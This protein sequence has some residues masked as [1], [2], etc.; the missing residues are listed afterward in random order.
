[1][2][3]NNPIVS[4]HD[5]GAGGLSNA[6]PELVHDA[7]RG[8]RFELRTIPNDDP[9]MSPMEIWCNEAQERYVLA[10]SAARLAE[11]EA[12]C[13]RERCPY[14]VIGEATEEQQLVLGDG[15][16][17]NTPIDIPMEVLLGKP[18]KM[19]REVHHKSVHKPD[20]DTSGIDLMEAALRVLRL[21]T[22][23]DKTFLVTIGDRTV[24]GLVT[25]DQMVGPW[26]VPVADVAVTSA[27]YLG[28]T[29][30]AMAIGERTPLALLHHAASARMAV[31]EAITNIAAA[32]IEH[33]GKIRLSANWMAPAGHPGEDAGLYEAVKAVGMELCPALGISIP[34]G[35]DSMSMKTVW[36]ENGEDKA[37]TAPLSL[38]VSAFAPVMDVEDTLTPQLRGSA[39]GGDLIF[40]DLG[41][42]ANR[43]GGSALAQ[44]YKQLGHHP[45]DLDDPMM[46]RAFF[47]AI[48]ELNNYGLIQAYHDRSDGGL[49]ATLC[50]MAFAGGSGLEIQLDELGSDPAAILFNEELGAVL[51]VAHQDTDEVLA[52]LHGYG[53]GGHSFV[54]GAP[55]DDKRISFSFEGTE[56]LGADRFEFR[57]AWS[58][59][60]Y[61]MQSLRDN[62]ECAAQEMAARLDAEDPGLHAALS[63]DPDDNV[64]NIYF[65]TGIRPRVAIL[66]EQGVNGQS[67][68][69]AAFHIAGFASVDVHMSDIISG[70]V[71]LKDFQGLAACG[72]FSYGDVLGA[73][74]GWAKSILFNPRARDEFE[75]FFQRDDSFGLGVCNGCQM[76]SNLHSLIPGAELWPHF[77]RNRSEQFEARLS[78]VEVLKSP[79]LFL[80]GMAGSRMPIAVAHGEGRAVFAD[81]GEAALAAGIVGLR[82]VDNYGQVTERYPANP[83][84]SPQG[85][86]G[87]SSRDGRFTIMMPHPER[88]FRS[89]QHSWAPEEWDEYA[90][91]M[92]LFRNARVWV[93]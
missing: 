22:V 93:D 43:L 6:M 7:G 90:S 50:E 56:V 15:H 74:E 61:H 62:P 9:G 32:D 11:F 86:T 34:V 58:E 19:L 41:K 27:S 30:E 35:K 91:W 82:Y 71:S 57:K 3:E 26:Q 70:E 49:F 73:G 92:R 88:V 79:S 4:I 39:D 12:L 14:A 77:E 54:I 21:P 20:F 67:E 78:M 60:S 25:R 40:I 13:E 48:Q 23:G 8:A 44:V 75:A 55:S 16:F 81:H 24:T 89:V 64:A 1:M 76:L 69:A 68:M 84:G 66:R 72:G 47:A 51:Q 53:L 10:I 28:Y 29:G 46:L 85:I 2:G 5:V 80:Q 45:P 37:V 38:I 63:F 17:D 87:L 52:A 83:N 65:H 42:G 36:R 59:T 31:G 33:L 18:P